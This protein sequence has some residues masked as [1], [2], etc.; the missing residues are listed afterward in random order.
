MMHLLTDLPI[1]RKLALIVGVFTLIICALFVLSLLGMG[2]LSGVRA[3]VGGEG[4]WS[5]SQKDAAYHLHRYTRYR[6]EAD[7]QKYLEY[8]AVPKGDHKAR[9]ELQKDNPDFQVIYQGFLEGKNHPEDLETMAT[10]FRRFHSVPSLEKS[11]NIWIEADRLIAQLDLV[12]QEI[13]EKV[14]LEKADDA[15]L[16]PLLNKLE[17]IMINLTPLEDDFSYSLG[18]GARWLT[19]LLHWIM[20]L[21]TGLFLAAGLLIAY[22]ISRQMTEEIQNLRG[23]SLRVAEGDYSQPLKLDSKDEIGDLSRTF[24]RMADQ[25]RDAERLKDEFFAN[26]SHEIR[27]PLTLILAP[28]ESLLSGDYGPLPEAMTGSVETMHNNA[29]RLLQMVSGLLDFSKL[30]AGKI[31]AHREP[32][33][34]ISVT[35]SILQDFRPMMLHK[36]ITLTFQNEGDTSPVLMDRYLYERILFNLLANAGK[37]TPEG[38]KIHVSLS[39]FDHRF[40]LGV[41]DTGI[42]IDTADLPHL[43]QKFRQLEGSSTRRFEGSGLGLALAKEFSMLL[44]G[45]ISAQSRLGEGTLFTVNGLAP[46]AASATTMAESK[47]S[48][49]TSMVQRFHPPVISQENETT[50]TVSESG[51]LPK[52]LVAEDNVEM[53]SYIAG[54]L[55]N[56]C[57]MMMAED[58]E[59]ALDVVH[60]WEPDL[61]ISD[62]MMPR[63]DGL[64]L[65]H[66]I[67]NHPPSA[68]IPVMLLTA[69]THRD[70]MIKGWEAGADEYLFKPFHPQELL[71]RVRSLL[72][73][74]TAKKRE[75]VLIKQSHLDLE[76]KIAER[77]SALMQSLKEKELLLREIHHRVKNNFQIITSLF[78]L[79]S[80]HIKDPGILETLRECQNRI[81]SIALI[82]EALY[83]SADL[84]KI[85]FSAH[86]RNLIRHLFQSYGVSSDQIV[87]EVGGNQIHFD[88]DQAVS[89]SVIVHEL[90]TNALKHAFPNGRKGHIDIHLEESP[91]EVSVAIQD[92]GIGLQT[93]QASPD[94]QGLG[95]QIV[96]SLASHLKGQVENSGSAGNGTS[97]S[98][99]IPK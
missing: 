24:Q 57:R 87:G 96:H 45:D 27:T 36:K 8:I 34:L 42:G 15:Q 31:E 67:K 75:A 9:L 4:L 38:G 93:T 7:Y 26:V 49:M 28:L 47:P 86:L 17:A 70:A 32:T 99:H 80:H 74:A 95:L 20:I 53:A 83:A 52:V 44:G 10:F 85:D 19:N 35:Q 92:D 2:F 11:I 79:Q 21:A 33:D 56:S 46:L 71:A 81:R 60:R 55:K 68:Q 51:N 25:R 22:L 98:I 12:A 37:F 43:F 3:Y 64:S 97:F 54:I 58:G 78:N 48:G 23:A 18:E 73:A 66:D 5:K 50:G 76:K 29:V 59:K 1:S 63:R 91:L 30:E 69:L 13:H 65:C 6:D 90:V 39:L 72:A 16:Q 88:M 77:T 40:S 82:H 84:S 41:R 61:V 89:C 62:V 14:S 94:R